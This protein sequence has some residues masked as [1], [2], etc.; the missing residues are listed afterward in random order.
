M[1][2]PVVSLMR[3]ASTNQGLRVNYHPTLALYRVEEELIRSTNTVLQLKAKDRFSKAKPDELRWR[4]ITNTS[5]KALPLSTQ[6]NRLRRRWAAAFQQSLKRQ[7]LGHN[8]KKAASQVNMPH[9]PE[10]AGTLELVI[11]EGHGFNEAAEELLRQT[12]H[13]VQALLKAGEGT[14]RVRPERQDGRGYG[15]RGGGRW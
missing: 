1:K 11:F 15:Q 7:G 12:N 10:I 6:R 13:V 2:T 14:R 8:G 4:V 3:Q 9:T 5:S